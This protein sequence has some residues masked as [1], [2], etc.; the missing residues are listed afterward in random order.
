M[1]LAAVI[2]IMNILPTVNRILLPVWDTQLSAAEVLLSLLSLSGLKSS[3][4][5]SFPSSLSGGLEMFLLAVV[6]VPFSSVEMLALVS[7]MPILLS[8]T[9]S[10]RNYYRQE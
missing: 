10:Y 9:M 3:V 8:R 6:L 2:N 1:I 5:A 4:P 7:S